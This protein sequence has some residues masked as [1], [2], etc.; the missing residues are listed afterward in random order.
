MKIDEIYIYIINMLIITNRIDDY[1]YT[2]KIIQE[3]DLE[4]IDLT[5]TMFE[6]LSKT[7]NNKEYIK[8]YKIIEANNIFNKKIINFYYILFKYIIKSIIYLYNNNFLLKTRNNFLKIIKNN[9]KESIIDNLD[10]NKKEKFE[11]IYNYIKSN[12]DGSINKNKDISIN[13]LLSK[14]TAYT[15]KIDSASGTYLRIMEFEKFIEIRHK[16]I[17]QIKNYYSKFIKEISNGLIISCGTKDILYIINNN[18]E[19]QQE[20]DF[21]KEIKE[22]EF[23]TSKNENFKFDIENDKFIQNIYE[24][25]IGKNS[26][27]IIGC[28]KY[29]LMEYII[30]LNSINN[31]NNN[32]NS[33][34]YI[35]NNK[36]LAC[37]F[38]FEINNKN[39]N[40]KDNNGNFKKEYIVAGEKG[41]YHFKDSPFKLDSLDEY[42]KSKMPYKGS[43]KINDNF[44]VLTSNRIYSKG[45]DKLVIYDTKKEEIMSEILEKK[46][47]KEINGSF[48]GGTNGLMLID[49][50]ENRKVII[51]AC[52][53]IH[54]RTK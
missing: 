1:E 30:N 7:L 42:S 50:E 9:S 6:E 52:K 41:L 46:E 15:S 8:N 37:T 22:I 5:K 35:L 13:S 54:F 34:L 43:I 51:C 29:E 28:S 40:N 23:P 11:Y 16:K 47:Q 10:G 36:K 45:K 32:E 2:Y 4:N 48:V 53:K 39:E 25:K 17:G 38:Y 26:V 20:I 19:I 31:N 24:K 14:Q 3:L 27:E 21:R 44:T 12:D 49:I 33:T 18:F